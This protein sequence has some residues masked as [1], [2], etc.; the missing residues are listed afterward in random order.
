RELRTAEAN[1]RGGDNDHPP[2]GRHRRRS[3]RFLRD[4]AHRPAAVG[5]VEYDDPMVLS[6]WV[7]ANAG[8]DHELAVA[9]E[10]HRRRAGV[11]PDRADDRCQELMPDQLAGRAVPDSHEAVELA[12]RKPVARWRP[13]RRGDIADGRTL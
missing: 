8:R 12:D 4:L 7:I 9:R 1:G 11:P 6:H 10:A 2:I 3:D 13:G 5:L